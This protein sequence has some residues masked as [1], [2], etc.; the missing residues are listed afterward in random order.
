MSRAT[1]LR[2]KTF[3]RRLGIRV[4]QGKPLVTL[5]SPRYGAYMRSIDNQLILL[6][7]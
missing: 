5:K 3:E 4:T 1:G 2:P 7:K 6:N